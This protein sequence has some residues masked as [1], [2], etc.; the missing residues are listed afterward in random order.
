MIAERPPQSKALTV[1]PRT[2]EIFALRGNL[3]GAGLGRT[4]AG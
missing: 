1:Y 3:L 2:V 4:V